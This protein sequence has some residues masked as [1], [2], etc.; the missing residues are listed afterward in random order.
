M[1]PSNHH[2]AYSL[3]HP[4][5][6]RSDVILGWGMLLA[7]QKVPGRSRAPEFGQASPSQG[8]R[9]LREILAGWF[10]GDHFGAFCF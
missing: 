2:V 8:K 4:S 1:I 7:G 5:V 3:A 6:A 10:F 9:R